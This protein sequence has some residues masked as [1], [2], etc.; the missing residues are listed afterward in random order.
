MRCFRIAVIAVLIVGGLVF[1]GYGA[2]V[3]SNA[4]ILTPE[5]AVNIGLSR[6]SD[7]NLDENLKLPAVRNLLAQSRA[8]RRGLLAIFAGS[9]L[10]ALG[11]LVWLFWD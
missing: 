11:T 5:Q 4:V 3:T 1:T 10:Q 8:A 7:E 2:W 6:F 9:V